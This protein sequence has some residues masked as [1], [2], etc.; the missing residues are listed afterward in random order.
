VVEICEF[1]YHRVKLL[2]NLLKSKIKYRMVGKKGQSG[3]RREGS[4]RKLRNNVPITVR[5]SEETAEW[6]HAEAWKR[7]P[8][9]RKLPHLGALFDEIVAEYRKRRE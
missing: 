2:A 3:G 9:G 5:V 6:L 7:T 4:G 8:A 1:W